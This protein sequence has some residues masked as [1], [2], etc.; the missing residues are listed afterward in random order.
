MI[1]PQAEQLKS[2]LEMLKDSVREHSEILEKFTTPRNPQ[3]RDKNKKTVDEM[4]KSLQSQNFRKIMKMRANREAM[5]KGEE[6]ESEEE[7]EAENSSQEEYSSENSDQEEEPFNEQL[8][9]DS[10]PFLV[11]QIPKLKLSKG[12]LAASHSSPSNQTPLQPLST[13]I[14]PNNRY[15]NLMTP[16]YAGLLPHSSHAPSSPHRIVKS[17]AEDSP[18]GSPVGSPRSNFLLNGELDYLGAK[19][20]P[21]LTP[22]IPKN[23]T[24]KGASSVSLLNLTN[25]K[26]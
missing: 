13:K 3:H 10:D 15:L 21:K 20:S 19:K 12:T 25:P 9:S 17:I 16:N 6:G 11:P 8:K 14:N 24:L 22:L 1:F 18:K 4:R 26:K 7:M 2:K 5:K 23:V